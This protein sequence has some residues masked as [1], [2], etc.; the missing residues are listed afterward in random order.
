MRALINRVVFDFIVWRLKRKLLRSIP[1]LR[2][3]DA[4]I[5]EERRHHHQTRALMAER[6]R[7]I[8]AEL[9]RGVGRV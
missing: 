4:Q 8:H 5:R 7:L 2:A 6:R 1:A 9:A 3:N